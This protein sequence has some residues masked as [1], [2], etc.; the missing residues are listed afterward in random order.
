MATPHV[1]G[2]GAL[3]ADKLLRTLGHL[4]TNALAAK[5]IASGAH[6]PLAPG[7]DPVDV[8]TGI[9]RAPQA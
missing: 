7:F 5:L 1:A 6:T 2:V 4:N 9:V 8:G 3:W